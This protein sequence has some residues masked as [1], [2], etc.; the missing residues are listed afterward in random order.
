MRRLIAGDTLSKLTSG[1]PKPALV[2][3]HRFKNLFELN[4]EWAAEA[5]RLIKANEQ[6]TAVLRTKV[7]LE[8][9]GEGSA[10]S[11]RTAE[12][13]KNGHVQ[14]MI[15]LH[16]RATRRRRCVMHCVIGTA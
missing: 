2:S 5:K 3:I 14:T 13:C 15:T 7:K 4:P 8:L 9:A 6:A 12:E 1:R 16:K 11:R 10:I